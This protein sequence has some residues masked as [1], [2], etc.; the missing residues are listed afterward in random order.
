MWGPLWFRR[1]RFKLAPARHELKDDIPY[2]HPRLGKMCG[3]RNREIDLLS[4]RHD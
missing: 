3:E 4:E 1:W 2:G